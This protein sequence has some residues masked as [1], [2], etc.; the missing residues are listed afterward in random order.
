MTASALWHDMV[1]AWAN[2]CDIY[3]VDSQGYPEDKL[4]WVRDMAFLFLSLSSFNNLEVKDVAVGYENSVG[5]AWHMAKSR[6]YMILSTGCSASCPS[7]AG[8]ERQC[9]GVNVIIVLFS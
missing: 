8:A 4:G 9:V 1:P 7:W 3:S 5:I 2:N 6:Q